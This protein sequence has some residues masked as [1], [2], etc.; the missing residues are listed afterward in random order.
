MSA[1]LAK[2]IESEITRLERE[3]EECKHAAKKS[4]ANPERCEQ[5]EDRLRAIHT[6]LD[7]L[8]LNL[9]KTRKQPSTK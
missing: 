4:L 2:A 6:R 9:L 5:I 1:K 3:V 7:E 8:R